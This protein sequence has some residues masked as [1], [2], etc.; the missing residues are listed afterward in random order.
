MSDWIEA[1]WLIPEGEDWRWES[2]MSVCEPNGWRIVMHFSD[3]LFLGLDELGQV[4][5]T[6]CSIPGVRREGD[7]FIV[8][9]TSRTPVEECLAW[10]GIQ[11]DWRIERMAEFESPADQETFQQAMETLK[12]DSPMCDN[13]DMH[14]TALTERR[15]G[16]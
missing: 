3:R 15:P 5:L 13:P 16:G 7:W 9:P 4:I 14:S 1:A 6:L 12:S 8:E 11:P 10:S 2:V